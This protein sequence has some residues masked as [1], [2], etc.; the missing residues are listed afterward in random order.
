M[1]GWNAGISFRESAPLKKSNGRRIAEAC[2]TEAA[3]NSAADKATGG[4]RY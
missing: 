2:Q 4:A 3:K 1:M